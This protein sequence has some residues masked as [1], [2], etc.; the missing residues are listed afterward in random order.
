MAAVFSSYLMLQSNF[1]LLYPMAVHQLKCI[2]HALFPPENCLPGNP[3]WPTVYVPTLTASLTIEKRFFYGFPKFIGSA[4]HDARHKNPA[5]T[6]FPLLEGAPQQLWNSGHNIKK[7]AKWVLGIFTFMDGSH[8]IYIYVRR[9]YFLSGNPQPSVIDHWLV[10]S[11]K[12]MNNLSWRGRS[13]HDWV[14]LYIL[15]GHMILAMCH[16]H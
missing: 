14:A 5:K 1:F 3:K 16:C 9:L 11:L 2:L 13:V 15:Y 8:V 6:N 4:L 12:Q 10:W 7:Y